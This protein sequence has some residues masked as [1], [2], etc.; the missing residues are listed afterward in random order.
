MVQSLEHYRV[1]AAMPFTRHDLQNADER[2]A[3]VREYVNR[4]RGKL[5]KVRAGSDEATHIR[6][7][8]S[9]LERMLRQFLEHRNRIDDELNAAEGSP[10]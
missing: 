8:L 2:I 9:A 3:Q 4:E 10:G 1:I 7:V 6:Q 5:S